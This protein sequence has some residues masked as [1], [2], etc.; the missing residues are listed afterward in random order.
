MTAVSASESARCVQTCGVAEAHAEGPVAV[1]RL[2]AFEV[3]FTVAADLI[4]LGR[5]GGLCRKQLATEC[6]VQQVDSKIERGLVNPTMGPSR[7]SH[8]RLAPGYACCRATSPHSRAQA[9]GAAG[10]AGGFSR[11]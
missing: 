11:T 5:E 8:G 3:Q 9:A 7:S 2:R 1:A 10:A 4:A 6:G